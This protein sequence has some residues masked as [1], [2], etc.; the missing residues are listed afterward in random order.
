MLNRTAVSGLIPRFSIAA[1][2]IGPSVLGTIEVL[3]SAHLMTVVAKPLHA[4]VIDLHRQA[5]VALLL[6][7]MRAPRAE[8]T[9]LA[10]A[11]GP[12]ADTHL[13]E[14]VVRGLHG[15]SRSS[16]RLRSCACCASRCLYS[17]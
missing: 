14:D 7:Q 9:K 3:T 12:L 2:P 17:I 8:R 1:T 6:P 13:V 10:A 5:R 4:Q 11:P 16:N 15:Q